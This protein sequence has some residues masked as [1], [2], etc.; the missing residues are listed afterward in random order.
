[1]LLLVGM[2]GSKGHTRI[3][4]DGHEQRPP[5]CTIDRATPVA[6]HAM[7]GS[8]DAPKLLGVDVQRVPRA[9]S[10]SLVQQVADS[11]YRDDCIAGNARLQHPTAAQLDDEQ[12]LG[13]VNGSERA[14]LEDASTRAAQP[15]S[16]CLS[17][18]ALGKRPGHECSSV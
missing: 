6:G 8:D 2:H 5:A 15:L 17:G 13:L 14:G 3:I 18:G 7:T 11:G 10:A 16:G 1:M 9:R 12:C 4:V